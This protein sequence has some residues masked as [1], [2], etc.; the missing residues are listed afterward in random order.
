MSPQSA[1][2]LF[3]NEV[4]LLVESTTEADPSKRV[5]TDSPERR[6]SK[7]RRR[8][9]ETIFESLLGRGRVAA[10]VALEGY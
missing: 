1:V 9:T 2:H 10:Y 7:S 3:R 4:S 6:Q 5:S 8:E